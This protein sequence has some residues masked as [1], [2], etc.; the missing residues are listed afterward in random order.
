[1]SALRGWGT[2]TTTSPD[3]PKTGG[4]WRSVDRRI[5]LAVAAI[6]GASLFLPEGRQFWFDYFVAPI[7]ADAIGP[8]GTA[9]A[10]Y[11]IYNTAAYGVLFYLG[12]IGVER[13][14]RELDI[15]VDGRFLLAATPLVLLG[16]AARA[17][18][19]AGLFAP[20][21]QYLFISPII[22]LLLGAVAFLLLWGGATLRDSTLP[23]LPAGLALVALAIGG[24]GAWWLF[25]PPGWVH[26]AVWALVVLAITAAVAEFRS[27]RP[28]HN[29]V[30]L[31]GLGSGLALLLVLLQL[32]QFDAPHGEVLFEVPLLALGLT[33]AVAGA[34]WLKAER[35]VPHPGFMLCTLFLGWLA[36]T[37][38][39]GH[40]FW[41][42]L[43][44]FGCLGAALRFPLRKLRALQ[45]VQRP[46]YLGLYFAHFLDGSATWL[47]IDRYGY[48]EKHVLP[49]GAIDYFGTAVVMLPLKFAVVSAVIWALE[50]EHEEIDHHTR[51]LLL[52]FLM[53]L[54]LAPGTRDIL[55]L[56]LGT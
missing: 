6:L 38:D 21:V 17:L 3:T 31:F 45:A 14:L 47:G 51:Y 55:R 41:L 42:V 1:M 11:N 28:L 29:P 48:V 4:W 44:A 36:L 37:A 5:L 12:F 46:E 34:A 10:R 56:A 13:I 23:S 43:A 9:G 7:V 20:P 15:V 35:G 50:A 16:G 33:L 27:S 52:L 40:A 49:S 26:P 22:Y 2:L 8:T 39:G 25:A 24:Y 19:D 32:A 18:E 54:G 53:T 30:E